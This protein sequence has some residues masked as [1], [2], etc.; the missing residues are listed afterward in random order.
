[1]TADIHADGPFALIP[2]WVLDAEISAQA[3]RLYGVLRRYA[4]NRTL[5]AHPSR[6]TLADRLHVADVKTVDRALAELVRVGAVTVTQRT[7][8]GG[9]DLDSNGYRLHSSSGGRGTDATTPDPEQPDE[10]LIPGTGRGVDATRVGAPVPQ[11]RGVDAT[12]VRAPVPQGVGVPMPQELKP[13]EL[14][15][16]QTPS[17][18]VLRPDVEELCS[19]LHDK[20]IANGSKAEVTQ[21]WRDAARRLLDRDE[22]PLA[23]ALALVDWCQADSFWQ[24]NI[25]SM[26]TFRKQYDKLRLRKAASNGSGNGHGNGYGRRSSLAPDLPTRD[27]YRTGARSF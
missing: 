9:S 13:L 22:R 5:L 21:G 17:V 11:G 7:R 23:E 26:P 24:A 15:T 1:M 19:R 6:R 12:R 20:I 18:S 16:T 14:P 2:E 27:A 25:L 4:D 3:V 8:P 10:L